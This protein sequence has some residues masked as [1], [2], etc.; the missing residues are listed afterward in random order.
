MKFVLTAINK[1]NKKSNDIYRLPMPRE[2]LKM[3]CERREIIWENEEVCLL[4]NNLLISAM[5]WKKYTL[6]GMVQ[7]GLDSQTQSSR[8]FAI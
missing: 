3:T 7:E 4:K 6:V 1:K 8:G 5:V 2:S